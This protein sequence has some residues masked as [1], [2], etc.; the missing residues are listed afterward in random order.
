MFPSEKQPPSTKAMPTW[1]IFCALGL[2]AMIGGLCLPGAFARKLGEQEGIQKGIQGPTATIPASQSRSPAEPGNG[3]KGAL[4]YEPPDL[5]EMA[6][7][8]PILLRLALGTIFVLILCIFTLW[9]GKRWV[10]PLAVPVGENRKLRVLESLPLSGRCSVFLLQAGET[11]VLVGIDPAGLKAL[12]PLPQS[13]EG[14]LAE[15]EK[16]AKPNFAT[17]CSQAKLENE[18]MERGAS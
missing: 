11:N 10:R 16:E 6:P 15:L 1:P 7:P 8:G 17:V 18:G 9:A 2:A 13:F 4:E 14:A 5:P 3:R 12:L